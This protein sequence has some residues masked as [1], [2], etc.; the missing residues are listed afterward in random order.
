MRLLYSKLV[1]SGAS[2]SII[3]LLGNSQ[4][5]GAQMKVKEI[6]AQ[7]VITVSEDSSLE[8]IAKMML[9]HRIACVPVANAS[10][11]LVGLVT[12][13]TFTAREKWLP[14][15]RLSLP[16]LFGHYLGTGEV[17]SIYEAARRIT[18]REVMSTNL[19]TVTEDELVRVV[20]E[21]MLRHGVNN[22]PVVKD[23]V[24]VGMVTRHDLLKMMLE[25]EH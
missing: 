16:Q 7:P 18:A 13:S 23:G 14:F 25:R 12:E 1:R 15:T 3:G 4:P 2:G 24:P 22:I 21:K 17:D 9:Q 10:S 20:L 8:E 11:K 5:A 6:M 19:I